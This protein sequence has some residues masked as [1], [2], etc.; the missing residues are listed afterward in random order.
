[1]GSPGAR[2]VPHTCGSSSETG[3]RPSGSLAGSAC[4]GKFPQ[5]ARAAPPRGAAGG[6]VAIPH[7]APARARDTRASPGAFLKRLPLNFPCRRQT[8]EPAQESGVCVPRRPGAGLA[9]PRQGDSNLSPLCSLSQAS[10]PGDFMR[11]RRL[12]AR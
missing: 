1:M 5:H 7:A 6:L 2:P 11:A 10:D 3:T 8:Q 4:G 12:S 9:A